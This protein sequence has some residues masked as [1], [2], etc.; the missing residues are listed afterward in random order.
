MTLCIG[1]SSECRR[2]CAGK[3]GACSNLRIESLGAGNAHFHVATVGGKQ[4]AISLCRQFAA[5]AIHDGKNRRAASARQVNRAIGIGSR[6]ALTDR[7]DQGV[8][9]VELQLK[10]RQLRCRQCVHLHAVV[11]H[12]AQQLRQAASS[13]CRSSLTNHTNPRESTSREFCA[14]IIWQHC[15]VERCL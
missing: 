1:T 15:C 11:N 3:Q 10:S 4:H 12:R 2:N 7:N 8:G 13:N 9:H 14:N 6:S 5:A